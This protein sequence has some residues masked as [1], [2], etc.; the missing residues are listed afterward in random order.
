[1]FRLSARSLIALRSLTWT[2]Q[3]G[4]LVR[5]INNA[6]ISSN[7]FSQASMLATYS[8]LNTVT[9]SL[10]IQPRFS[11]PLSTEVPPKPESSPKP[12][13]AQDAPA[14]QDHS[15]TAAVDSQ[16]QSA[17]SQSQSLSEVQSQEQS[18][19]EA[20]IDH[21]DEQ[22]GGREK[23]PSRLA[24]AADA[25]ASKIVNV[26]CS[27]STFQAP[28]NPLGSGPFTDVRPSLTCVVAKDSAPE[29][30]ASSPDSSLASPDSTPEV[31]SSQSEQPNPDT[32]PS[33]QLPTNPPQSGQS[34]QQGSSQS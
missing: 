16:P 34:Q 5:C 18:S 32:L 15:A 27:A 6:G 4:S 28:F 31:H 17:S 33:Q 8:T 7:S 19:T 12:E 13:E 9:P 30:D 3:A 24:S 26:I 10:T 20:S 1:M 14:S 21:S 22:N 25:A 29:V 11:R 2:S 23:H